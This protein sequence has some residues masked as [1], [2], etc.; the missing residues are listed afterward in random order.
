MPKGASQITQMSEKYKVIIIGI[1]TYWTVYALSKDFQI[2]ILC[3]S[4]KACLQVEA[5]NL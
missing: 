2:K 3:E 1:V 5:A 4:K